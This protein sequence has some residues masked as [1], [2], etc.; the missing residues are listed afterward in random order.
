MIG[1][2]YDLEQQGH[3]TSMTFMATGDSEAPE[4]IHS[5][6]AL[7]QPKSRLRKGALPKVEIEPSGVDLEDEEKAS[8]VVREETPALSEKGL[9]PSA[10]PAEHPGRPIHKAIGKLPLLTAQ[11]EVGLGRRIEAGQIQLRRAL[12]GIPVAT[13]HLLARVDRIRHGEA[14]LDEVIV[15]PEGGDPQPEE[16]KPLLAVFT[17]IRRLEREIGR[18]QESL[19]DKRRGKTTRANYHKWVAQS[20][21]AI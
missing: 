10:G 20:P 5:E 2:I 9:R 19:R 16:I 12:A 1:R 4:T 14:G 17:R 21:A 8:A 11:Q 3:D 18:L 7:A 6:A 13:T 15:L